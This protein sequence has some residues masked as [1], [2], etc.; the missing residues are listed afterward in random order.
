MILWTHVNE[1]RDEVGSDDFDEV[2]DLFLEEVG[3]AIDRLHRDPDRDNLEQGLHFLKGSALSLGFETF[4]D[5]CQEGERQAAAGQA[6]R[7][8]IPALIGVF[9]Q[10][11]ALFLA[12]LKQHI[13]A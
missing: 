13:A 1:L 3:E 11:R 4:S 6:E 5:L 8:D 9:E 10:S 2:V 12:G 7:V